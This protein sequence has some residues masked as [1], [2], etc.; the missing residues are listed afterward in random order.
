MP[1]H[2]LE[3]D[4]DDLAAPQLPYASRHSATSSSSSFTSGTYTPALRRGLSSPA[5][6]DHHPS[7][8][9]PL[10]LPHLPRSSSASHL[11]PPVSTSFEHLLWTK[12][13]A[14]VD[15]FLHD[16]SPLV[17]AALDKRRWKRHTVPRIVDIL[18]LVLVVI[19]L[20]GVFLGWPVL[21][22]GILGSWGNP[23]SG[24]RT[25]LGW[26]LG[27]INAT[28]SVPLIPGLPGLV[29]TDTP[30][31]AYT[32][33]GFFD[34]EVYNLVYSDEFNVDGRTFWPGD[35]PYWEAVDLR[36]VR[37]LFRFSFMSENDPDAVTTKDGK[38]VITLDQ[39]PWNGLNFRSGMLQSWDKFCFTGGYL[40]ISA[41]F[42]GNA[43][44]MGFWPGVWT[45]G[46]LGRAGYGGSVDGVWP[47]SYT[48]CDVGTLPNQTYPD[49]SGPDAARHSGL[50]DYGGSLSYLPGQRMSACTCEGEDHPGPSVNVGR[51]AP[52]IDVTGASQSRSTRARRA[53]VAHLFPSSQ[54]APM[55]AGYAW[56][57]ETPHFTIYN[58]TRSVQNLFTGAV[59]QESASIIS[60]TDTTSYEGRGY[61]TFGFEY[62]PG[63]NGV[64]TWAVNRTPTWQITAGAMGLNDETEIGQRL[65]SME[66]MAININLAISKA[67]QEPD[68]AHLTFPGTF[69][70]D[71]VRLWQKGPPRIGCDPDDHPTAAYIAR[72]SD[73]YT[74]PNL[75]VFPAPFPQNRLSSTGCA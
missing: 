31:E 9:A 16:P 42:P 22:F 10:A 66:P 5:S 61:S 73:V 45:L 67:F 18:S 59:Y 44:T 8:T 62:E 26:N 74:N 2:D 24:A 41:S 23:H 57:N 49:Q 51:G 70:I 75:T 53:I 65:V 69:R 1:R 3:D 21:R 39:E 72:H 32:R 47:Y 28:G 19:A 13:N 58:D 63:P 27:G 54:F 64:I 25:D 68:W 6:V 71:Y 17:D 37:R 52:E 35:D 38:L 46:N 30:L 56:K 7:A 40:E 20:L 50:R 48:S 29:D 4:D 15:D 12:S 36:Y 34:G 11:Y 14:S 55:D 33:Q 60:L 43:E